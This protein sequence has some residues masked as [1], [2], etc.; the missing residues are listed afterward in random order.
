MIFPKYVHALTQHSNASA[1]RIRNPERMI[2]AR[3]GLKNAVQEGF[4]ALLTQKDKHVKILV[5]PDDSLT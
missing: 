2:T 4:E 5:T 3:I 1:G